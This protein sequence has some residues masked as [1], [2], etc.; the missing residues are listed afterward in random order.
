MKG[1]GI[2]VSR[3]PSPKI[4]KKAS[5]ILINLRGETGILG[6]WHT[7]GGMGWKWGRGGEEDEGITSLGRVGRLE[8]VEWSCR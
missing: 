6:A 7:V 2:G 8:D 1:V 4:S 3:S 5:T